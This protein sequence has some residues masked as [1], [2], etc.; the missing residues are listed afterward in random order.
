MEFLV[1]FLFCP[2]WYQHQWLKALEGITKG[3][4]PTTNHTIYSKHPKISRE[5]HRKTPKTIKGVFLKTNWLHTLGKLRKDPKQKIRKHPS[6][7]D[8]MKGPPSKANHTIY[9]KHHKAKT[10]QKILKKEY[11]KA[12]ENR[13]KCWRSLSENKIPFRNSLFWNVLKKTSWRIS[14]NVQN[15]KRA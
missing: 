8:N 13:R 1:F 5:K 12:P 7:L 14:F 2:W 10:H 6:I 3:P 9:S 11:R 4:L 15:C